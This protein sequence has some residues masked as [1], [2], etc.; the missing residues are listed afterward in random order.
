MIFDHLGHDRDGKSISMSYAKFSLLELGH[1]SMTI[2]G[3]TRINETLG[4]ISDLRV[5]AS[6]LTEK[7]RFFESLDA[8]VRDIAI[9]LVLGRSISDIAERR[10]VS[11]RTIENHRGCVSKQLD[12]ETPLDLAKLLTS[13]RKTGLATCIF[14]QTSLQSGEFITRRCCDKATFKWVHRY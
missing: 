3:I 13:C 5:R 2:L 7:W 4:D 9:Q 8:D 1:R 6:M 11:K 14:D 12:V 10:S